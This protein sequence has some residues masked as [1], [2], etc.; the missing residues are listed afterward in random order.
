MLLLG[1]LKTSA[2]CMSMLPCVVTC[3]PHCRIALHS[4]HA[5][6]VSP[7]QGDLEEQQ[8]QA[9]QLQAS[10]QEQQG[11]IAQLQAHLREQQGQAVQL[12]AS[13][14]EQQGQGMQ[15]QASLEERRAQVLQLAEQLQAVHEALAG[16]QSNRQQ[17]EA[18]LGELQV[19]F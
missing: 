19:G 9:L 13:L 7:A 11:Q 2:C 8:G 14:Q 6:V 3:V 5:Y 4:W 18:Q 12:Q 15:L 1:P 10:L 16:E 17:L